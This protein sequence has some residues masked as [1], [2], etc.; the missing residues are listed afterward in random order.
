PVHL[1]L[2]ALSLRDALPIYAGYMA[3]SPGDAAA[4]TVFIM[5][6]TSVNIVQ[7]ST[8]E[9]SRRT[10]SSHDNEERPLTCQSPVMP[11]FTRNRR[12]TDRKS[13]R[14]NSSHVKISYA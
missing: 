4:R 5:I 12:C 1:D 7:F 11:G 2:S 13:T 8:Y 3:V 9:R 6:I 10:V 14:L